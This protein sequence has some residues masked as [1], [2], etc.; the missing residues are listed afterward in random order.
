MSFTPTTTKINNKKIE[1][2][3]EAVSDIIELND[4]EFN[5]CC[6]ND[7][8]KGVS[9]EDVKDVFN[10]TKDLQHKYEL[11]QKDMEILDLKNKILQNKSKK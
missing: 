5:R 10:K 7:I 1:Y 2:K 3:V 11:L 9:L 8:M 6:V 4:E